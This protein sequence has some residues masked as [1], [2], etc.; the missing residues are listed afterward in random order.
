[1]CLSY[2]ELRIG[3]TEIGLKLFTSVLLPLL[4]IG[5]TLAFFRQSGKEPFCM[6]RFNIF[7]KVC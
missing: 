4:Y 6:L 7:V 1:M 5:V 2:I 3:K